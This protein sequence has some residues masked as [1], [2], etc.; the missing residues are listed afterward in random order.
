MRKLD[1]ENS[2]VHSSVFSFFIVFKLFFR[3]LLRL[4][5]KK[6]KEL[7]DIVSVLFRLIKTI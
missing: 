2:W 4:F 5:R 3:E 6:I 7:E 1:Q